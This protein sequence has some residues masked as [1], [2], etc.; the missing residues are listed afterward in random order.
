[1]VVLYTSSSHVIVFVIIIAHI[2]IDSQHFGTSTIIIAYNSFIAL[3]DHHLCVCV[4]ACIVTVQII[5]LLFAAIVRF[6]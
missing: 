1:M 2:V 4:C 3:M 6:D 5:Q